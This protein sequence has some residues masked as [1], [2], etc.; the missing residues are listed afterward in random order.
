MF[1]TYISFVELKLVLIQL[2]NYKDMS[3]NAVAVIS[4]LI[5]EQV[6]DR[7]QTI[8]DDHNKLKLTNTRYLVHYRNS[9]SVIAKFAALPV[10][11]TAFQKSGRKEYVMHIISLH[12]A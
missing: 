2:L 11:Q 8:I 4:T 7:K 9:L 6:L 10:C 5:L 3:R 1:N 12:S